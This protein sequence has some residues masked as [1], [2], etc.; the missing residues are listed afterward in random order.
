MT[1]RENPS[2]VM[3]GRLALL[4]VAVTLGC[5]G[6]SSGTGNSQ[7]AGQVVSGDCRPVKALDLFSLGL[8]SEEQFSR[9]DGS[10]TIAAPSGLG[11]GTPLPSDSSQANCTIIVYK[12]GAIASEHSYLR[13]HGDTCTV[14]DLQSGSRVSMAEVC[15]TPSR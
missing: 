9:N 14:K 15:P 2:R 4:I 10:F 5:G 11:E 8:D 12:N 1:F 13:A 3:W 6:G 7:T